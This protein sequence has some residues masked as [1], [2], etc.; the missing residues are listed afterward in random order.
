MPSIVPVLLNT[1]EPPFMSCRRCL[2]WGALL[3]DAARSYAEDMRVVI[4]A[5]GGLSHSIGVPTMGM[6]NERFDRE[7]LRHFASCP[8]DALAKYLDENLAAGGNG[9]Q[10]IRS[11]V[12]AHGSASTHGFELMDYLPVPE[13]YV[14][15]GFAKWTL[16]PT[17]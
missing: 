16:S 10:E 1:V 11:W 14:G 15:C 7:C 17:T 12:V 9:A 2:Q 6:I 3:A 4:L 5:T 13:V 8:E